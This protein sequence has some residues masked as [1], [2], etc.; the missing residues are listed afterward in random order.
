MISLINEIRK[1]QDSTR[2]D[3]QKLIDINE[4]HHLSS[5]VMKN[6]YKFAVIQLRD[7]R[8]VRAAFLD[9]Q[10]YQLDSTGDPMP[11]V[12]T[13]YSLISWEPQKNTK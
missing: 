6:D 13:D 12:Y 3:F 2:P 9:G 5:E 4:L 11:T 10:C 1:I 8:Q 7:G